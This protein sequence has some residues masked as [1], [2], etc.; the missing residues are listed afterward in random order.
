MDLNRVAGNCRWLKGFCIG[1]KVVWVV[2][3][4]FGVQLDVG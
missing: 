1:Y 3:G 2:C 4:V